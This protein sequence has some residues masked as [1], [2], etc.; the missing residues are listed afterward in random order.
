MIHDWYKRK[1]WCE[2]PLGN[3]MKSSDDARELEMIL[4][5]AESMGLGYQ[6][7]LSRHR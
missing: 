2:G 4:R 3:P 5:Q 1:G 6:R 7:A